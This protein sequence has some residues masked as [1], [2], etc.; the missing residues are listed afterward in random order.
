MKDEWQTR[1]CRSILLIKLDEIGDM[2]LASPAFRVVREQHPKGKIVCL[3]RPEVLPL[4]QQCP[5]VDAFLPMPRARKSFGMA[6]IRLLFQILEFCRR[7]RLFGF[8][9]SIVLRTTPYVQECILSRVAGARRRVGWRNPELWWSRY[10][11]T[12]MISDAAGWHETDRLASVLGPPSVG[13]QGRKLE[14]WLT[15]SDRRRPER[16]GEDGL[17]IAIGCGSSCIGKR[18]WPVERYADVVKRMHVLHPDLSCV[19]VGGSDDVET[20]DRLIDLTGEYV[21]SVAGKLSLR[22]SCAWL[23]RCDCFVGNDSGPMHMAAAVGLPVVEVSCHPV[24]GSTEHA[25]APERFGPY[26]VPHVVCRPAR[27]LEPC[28]DACTSTVAHCILSVTADNVAEALAGL[29]PRAGRTR[30]P[31]VAAGVNGGEGR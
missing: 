22:E 11:F 27:A 6:K 15:E 12:H 28:A 10:C 4:V 1:Q 16:W 30:E 17:C 9:M 19:I 7:N 8:D 5:Y 3:V 13:A 2:V 29:T 20:A 21:T 23:E 18:C 31:A 25:N 24:G 26:G 14:V